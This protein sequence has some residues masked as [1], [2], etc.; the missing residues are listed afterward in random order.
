[1]VGLRNGNQIERFYMQN[2]DLNKVVTLSSLGV[3]EEHLLNAVERGQAD[4]NTALP[5]HPANTPGTL[6]FFGT[7]SE[8]RNQLIPYGWKIHNHRNL[9]M[10]SH[11]TGKVSIVVSGGTKETGTSSIPTTRN[12]KGELAVQYTAQNTQMSLFDVLEETTESEPNKPLETQ[13]WV[14]LYYFDRLASEVRSEL[15]LPLAVDNSGKVGSWSQRFILPALPVSTTEGDFN[16]DFDP[17]IELD[18]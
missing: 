6:A 8:L 12:P 15:S 13:T 3:N 9:S 10:T 5:T 11:P 17:E 14:L 16:P 1:M 2:L 4:R 7:V 18:I